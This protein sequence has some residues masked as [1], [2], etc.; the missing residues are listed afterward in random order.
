[1]LIAIKDTIPVSV[2]SLHLPNNAPEAIAVRLN[3]RIPIILSCVYLLPC[4]SDPYMEVTISNLTQIVQSDPSTVSIIVGDFNLPDVQWDTLSSTSSSS[5]TFCDFVFDNSL[6][7]LIN[8]P[9]HVKGNILDLVLT[10][11]ENSIANLTIAPATKWITTDHFEITFQLPQII[12]PTPTTSPKYV[13]DFPKAN[14]DGI[15]SY[16]FDF[17]YT[18]CLQSHNVE[19]VWLT[20]KNSIYTAMDIFI[21]KVRLR[22]HQFPCWYTSELRHLSKCLLSSKKRFSKHPTP[23]LQLKINNLE[24]DYCSKI[25]QAKYNY[26]MHLVQSFAGSCNGKIYDYIRSLSKKTTIPSMVSHDSSSATSDTG[27]AELFNTFFHSVFT[28]S[29]FSLPNMSSLPLPSSCICTLKFSDSEALSSLDPTKSSGCDNIGPKLLKHCALALYTPLHHLFSLSLSKQHIPCEW[30]CHSITPIFK[31]G[32]K[33]LVKNYRPISLLCIVSKVLEHLIYNKISKFITDNNI[34]YMLSSICFPPKPFLNSAATNIFSSVLNALNNYSRCDVI[35]FDFKKAFDRVPHQ[36]LLLKLW[37]VGIVGGLWRWF[38][39][40]L[41]NRYHCVC[42][43]NSS[44]STLPVISGVPQ[45]SLLGLL[46]FL[47]YINDAPSSLKHSES[48]LFADDIKCLRPICSPHDCIQLQS[49]L[50]ALSLWS[51]NWKL[52]FNE[53]KCS[54]L[55]IISGHISIEQSEQQYFINEQLITSS[56]QQKDLGILISSNLS[57]S[58]HAS[59]ITSKAY[60]ILGL[61]R[62]TFCSSAN[63]ATKKRLYISLVRSQFSHNQTRSGSYRKLV[64]PLLGA[65]EIS[66]STLT[67]YPTCGTLFH[68]LT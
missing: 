41:S 31:S 65:I 48:F 55:S 2:L 58:H 39:D 20:I 7:Q 47:I 61:I 63:V 57:W 6:I 12:H 33:S 64:Q 49:D 26:E 53:T 43:N 67:D 44:S 51:I 45:G 10:N 35:Y 50:D 34:L 59:K 21:P 11:S 16:L 25:N 23:H 62:R 22:H 13:F 68:L 1:M 27:K 19:F 14:Y 52:M 17:D 29:P 37:K 30:K 56:N 4:L 9:T 54:F 36:E 15:L 38:R 28:N 18:S 5:S 24:A 46:L 66:N 3:L 32:D 40:Y 60:K 42:I 8:H